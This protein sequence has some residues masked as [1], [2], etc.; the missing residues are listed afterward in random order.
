ID[1]LLAFPLGLPGASTGLLLGDADRLRQRSR[2]LQS[3]AGLARLLRWGLGD[4]DRRIR[5]RRGSHEKPAPEQRTAGEHAVGRDPLSSHLCPP[6]PRVTFTSLS[7][8]SR[9]IPMPGA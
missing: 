5:E 8:P 4:R 1:A 9:T 7:D 6:P 2:R 3:A